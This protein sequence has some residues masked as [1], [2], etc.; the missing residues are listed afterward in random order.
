MEPH[1]A[2]QEQSEQSRAHESSVITALMESA[3]QILQ[4]YSTQWNTSKEMARLEWRITYRS[5]WFAIVVLI[6]FSGVVLSACIALTALVAY[7]LYLLGV[8]IWATG[9]A[10]V[11]LHGLALY[12]LVYMMRGL[13]KRMG[14]H[15]TLS[16][17]RAPKSAQA[18]TENTDTKE[19]S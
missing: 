14:F 2:E 17:L 5:L 1:N 7:G 13:I 10:L 4:R 9:L 19:A 8:P 18:N 16:I 6:I 15:Q 11:T 3:E 12:T